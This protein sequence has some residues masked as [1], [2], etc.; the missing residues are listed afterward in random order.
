MSLNVIVH[1][2]LVGAGAVLLPSAFLGAGLAVSRGGTITP[3]AGWMT[4]AVS[5][6]VG[7][8]CIW[9]MPVRWYWRLI[10]AVAS[11]AVTSPT[12]GFYMLAFACSAYRQCP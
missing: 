6:L 3:F 8:V 4:L 5:I 9:K 1:R 2:A 12:L 11:V 10:V 7:A